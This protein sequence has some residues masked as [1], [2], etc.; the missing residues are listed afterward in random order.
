[1]MNFYTDFAIVDR[2][3]LSSKAVTDLSEDEFDTNV[4]GPWMNRWQI[5]HHNKHT[6]N[7]KEGSS[8]H[9]H[10]LGDKA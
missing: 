9:S 5:V 7:L 6:Q 4:H 1:M 3:K 2:I 8:W 10:T